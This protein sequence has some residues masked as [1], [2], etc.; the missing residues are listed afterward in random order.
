MSR[1]NGKRD[2]EWHET[3]KCKCRLDANV[4]N[5]KQRWNELQCFGM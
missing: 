5:Y 1:S 3:F 4:C 2:I